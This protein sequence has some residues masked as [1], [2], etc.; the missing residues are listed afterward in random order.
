MQFFLDTVCDVAHIAN[1]SDIKKYSGTLDKAACGTIA[2]RFGLFSIDKITATIK[3][4]L[5]AKQT[6]EV[7]GT[8]EA[9]LTQACVITEAPLSETLSLSVLERYVPHIDLTDDQIEID[10][11]AVNV[12]LL[13]NGMIP[14]GELVQQSIGLGV[15]IHPRAENAPQTYHSGPEIKSEN[16]F[17]SLSELKK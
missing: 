4:K 7:S 13:E 1:R 10:V 6:W 14:L 3:V 2:A 8:I 9:E 17:Q 5:I 11:S 15:A 16:P 12:E